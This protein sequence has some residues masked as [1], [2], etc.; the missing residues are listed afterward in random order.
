MEIIGVVPSLCLHYFLCLFYWLED[1]LNWKSCY[2]DHFT[3]T[4]CG[5]EPGS[6]HS[7]FLHIYWLIVSS[8]EPRVD[9]HDRRFDLWADSHILPGL[10]YN[11][12]A[13]S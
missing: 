5:I 4:S 10:P 13:G 11:T 1:T 8:F 12:Q 6:I 3:A 2:I 7:I 9:N